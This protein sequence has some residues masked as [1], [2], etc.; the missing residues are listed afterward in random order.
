MGF[1]I[2]KKVMDDPGYCSENQNLALSLNV[3]EKKTAQKKKGTHLH[4][5]LGH[6]RVS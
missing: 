5:V 6:S 4:Q 1:C 2:R 3:V